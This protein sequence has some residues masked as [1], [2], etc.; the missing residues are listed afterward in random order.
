MEAIMEK[1]KKVAE[2]AEIFTFTSEEIPVQFEANCL[3]QI[4]SKQIQIV[5]LR[6]IKEGKIGYSTT[7]DPDDID[8]LVNAAVETAKYGTSAKLEFP[9]PIIYP[10]VETYDNE[11]ETITLEQMIELGEEMITTVKQHTSAIVCEA[12]VSKD[13]VSIN[14]MNSNGN[15]ADYKK[16]IFS[17]GIEGSLIQGTDMLFV[18]ENQSSCRP[19]IDSKNITDN[20]IKQLDWARNHSVA[21]SKYMPVIFTSTGVASALVNPLITAFNG[22][23]VLEGASPIGDSLNEPVFDSKLNLYDDAT[24]DYQPSSLPFDDEGVVSRRTPLIEAGVP[25]NFLYDLQTAAL[26]DKLSTGNGKRLSGR[27]PT[28]SPNAFIIQPG[29]VS[30]RNMIADIKDGLVIEYLMG[31][32]QGNILGGDFSGNVLLGYKVE[33]GKIVGRVKDTMVSGNVYKILNNIIAIGNDSRWVGSFL[34]SPSIYCSNLSVTVS[35]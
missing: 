22:K 3:K 12:I 31:A 35:D 10:K 1:V 2:S 7:T 23:M 18:A 13:I 28:P 24:I 19:L 16:S 9:N 26:A 11:V 25:V 32:G 6:I 14:I 34:N 21:S 5:A 8:S 27:L 17:L 20:V 4:Q 29:D 15:K 33:N 30:F